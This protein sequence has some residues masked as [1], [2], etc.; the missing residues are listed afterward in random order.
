[1]NQQREVVYSLRKEAISKQDVSEPI[2]EFLDSILNE[3]YTGY[4]ASRGNLTAEQE[5][6]LRAHLQEI[7]NLDR[8]WQEERIPSRE[9][10]RICIIESLEGIKKAVPDVFGDILRY[11]LLEEIDRCWKEHLLNMDHLR[12]GIGLRGYGQR[13]PKQEYK[14]EGFALFQDMVFRIQENIFKTLTRLKF[15]ISEGEGEDGERKTYLGVTVDNNDNGDTAFA[16][17]SENEEQIDAAE[18]ATPTDESATTGATVKPAVPVHKDRSHNV[19]YS[20]G[21]EQPEQ[22]QM[23][24]G[25]AGPKIGRNDDCPC[26]SG[27]KYKKC[28]G[29]KA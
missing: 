5:D 17:D 8:F 21:G 29:S 15:Q 12:D 20:A 25:N 19:A 7:F 18:N 14:R 27:K 1:M 11:F 16:A 22:K 10:M 24:T 2:Y 9:E 28:C 23:P 4:E 6:A 3:M 26:G 13:D